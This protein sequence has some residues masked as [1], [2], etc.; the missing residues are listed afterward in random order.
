MRERRADAGRMADEGRMEEEGGMADER[1]TAEAERWRPDAEVE[2]RESEENGR[3]N[4]EDGSLSMCKHPRDLSH[5]HPQSPWRE[6]H[7]EG[8][9]TRIER[10]ER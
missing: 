8:L 7:E 6:D 10:G 9:K 3:R 2:E 1:R 5:T 4:A